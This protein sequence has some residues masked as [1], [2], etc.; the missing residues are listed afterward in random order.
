MSV[1]IGSART[2]HTTQEGQVSTQGYYNPKSGYWLGFEPKNN[3]KKLANAMNQACNN[4]KIGYSQPLREEAWNLYK[5]KIKDIDMYCHTD[6]SALVR[7]CIRQAYG[8]SLPNFWTGIEQK[9]LNDSGLFKPPVKITNESQC[10]L[11]MI[12]LT[13]INQH[14]VIVTDCDKTSSEHKLQLPSCI[15]MLHSGS[16]GPQVRY[17]QE[18][19]NIAMSSHLVVDGEFGPKTENI[20]RAF[21]LQNN[22]EV[23][24]I[25]GIKTQQKLQKKLGL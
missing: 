4:D 14:T 18:C 2:S 15:P 1:L 3:G 7:L 10:T 25:Y 19:L 21:Q 24:G 9:I 5:T 11:G 6:C 16:M 17:L 23:D 12:L 13:E 20:L 8:I 22:L